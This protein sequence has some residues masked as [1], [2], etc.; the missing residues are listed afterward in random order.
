[1]NDDFIENLPDFQRNSETFLIKGLKLSPYTSNNTI[2][3]V[4]AN[5]YFKK[6]NFV[7]FSSSSTGKTVGILEMI[8]IIQNFA[9]IT[10]KYSLDCDQCFDLAD[11]DF[12]NSPVEYLIFYNC[13]IPFEKINIEKHHISAIYDYYGLYNP[14]EFKNYIQNYT[15]YFPVDFIYTTICQYPNQK[16]IDFLFGTDSSIKHLC[17]NDSKAYVFAENQPSQTAIKYFDK[18]NIKVIN[19]IPKKIK[20]NRLIFY[21]ISIDLILSVLDYIDYLVIIYTKDEF[22]KLKVIYESLKDKNV[23]LPDFIKNN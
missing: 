2:V 9:I 20:I 10:D 22:D 14:S 6:E 15:S 17:I 12:N 3:K 8:K 18:L 5:Y 13:N 11:F 1:M 23:I 16:K 4:I 19:K 21:D 7:L